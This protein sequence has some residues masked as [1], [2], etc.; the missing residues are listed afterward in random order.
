MIG[1]ASAAKAFHRGERKEKPQRTQRNRKKNSSA[2]FFATSA[3]FLCALRGE[4]LL[5]LWQ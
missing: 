5:K 4:R 2:I 1:D 3:A